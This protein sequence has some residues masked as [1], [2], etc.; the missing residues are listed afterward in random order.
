M[1]SLGSSPAPHTQSP[2][3]PLLLCDFRGVPLSTLV[4]TGSVRSI[5]PL[6]SF[7][8]ILHYC[9]HQGLSPPVLWDT[10]SCC[11]SISGQILPSAGVANIPSSLPGSDFMY[12]FEFIVCD[13]TIQSFQCILG[14]DFIVAFELQL[15]H[16]GN[17]YR[18]SGPH[19]STPL[20][21]WGPASPL[22]LTTA[23]LVP[24]LPGRNFPQYLNSLL[25]KGQ[26]LLLLLTTSLYQ[27]VA[28]AF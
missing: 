19:G 27:V 1:Y 25:A 7:R 2:C 26:L 15:E 18:V 11:I 21:P 23:W 22:L 16:S 20:H 10:A 3:Q 12:T 5:L 9:S 4:D 14:W 28:S 8:S 24:A 13:F 17:S 6:S